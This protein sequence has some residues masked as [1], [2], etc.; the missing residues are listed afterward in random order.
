MRFSETLRDYRTT[1]PHS[2]HRGLAFWL[3]LA[4]FLL[5]AL[6]GASLDAQDGGEVPN[7]HRRSIGTSVPKPVGTGSEP[8]LRLQVRPT[9]MLPLTRSDIQ[10]EL[11]IPRHAH[12]RK[13]A[14]AWTSDTGSEGSTVHDLEGEASAVLQPLLLRDQPA[15]HYQFGAAVYDHVGQIVDRETA[16]TRTFTPEGHHP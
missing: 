12:H 14:I 3:A 16:E 5:G 4:M 13:F 9:V 15:G 8:C 10:V 6:F 1:G 11:R 7:H 2:P